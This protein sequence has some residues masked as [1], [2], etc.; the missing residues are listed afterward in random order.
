MNENLRQLIDEAIKL[1]LNVADIYL[2]FHYRFPEDAGFWWKIAIEEKNHAAL[3]RNGK[4]F[5]LDAGMFPDELVDTSLEALVG[6]NNELERILQ[7]EKGDDPP[8]REA[9]L[10]IAIKLEEL[11]GEIHF[12]NAMQQAQ[13][14]SEAI[15]LLQNLNED[16]KD[17]ADRIRNYMRQH[18]IEETR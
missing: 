8:S 16:D 15:K 2:S 18:G 11:A 3:L 12:Q 9:A 5:F 6:V 10:N 7:Q 14:P 17:H 13:H 1:E 4:Q